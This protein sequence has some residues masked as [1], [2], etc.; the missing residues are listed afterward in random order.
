MNVL[1]MRA[2]TRVHHKLLCTR[3]QNYTI[4]CSNVTA[5]TKFIAKK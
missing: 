2:C 3:L 4:V 1:G 5:V